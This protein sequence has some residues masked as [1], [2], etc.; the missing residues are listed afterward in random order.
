MVAMSGAIM[1]APLA[2]PLMVTSVPPSR[3][4][5][6]ANFANVSVVMIA[7]AASS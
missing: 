3:A 4:R 2:K 5:A 7:L 1:P 6:V